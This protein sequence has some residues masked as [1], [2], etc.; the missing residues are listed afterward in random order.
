M[1]RI[2][3][4]HS[5]ITQQ[6]LVHLLRDMAYSQFLHQR[7]S[8]T[9]KTLL[10]ST[11]KEVGQ[12]IFD[13]LYNA[14]ELLEKQVYTENSPDIQVMNQIMLQSISDLEDLE[15]NH[16]KDIIA[17]LS[18]SKSDALLQYIAQ[19]N[20]LKIFGHC[21]VNLVVSPPRM[22]HLGGFFAQMLNHLPNDLIKENE[23]HFME[24]LLSRN[25]FAH[26]LIRKKISINFRRR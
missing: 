2:F 6:I 19:R 17:L 8:P 7:Y 13:A 24:I 15:E 10:L 4:K 5:H 16:A 21:K 20:P 1:R 26:K 18:T 3:E 12:Y 25:Y 14:F 22:L 11:S 9:I 23:T